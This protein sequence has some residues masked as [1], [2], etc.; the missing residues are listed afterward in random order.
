[1]AQILDSKVP[2]TVIINWNDARNTTKLQNILLSDLATSH[3][4]LILIMICVII[5][6]TGK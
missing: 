1:M 2:Q 5:N 6:T 3:N 4:Y